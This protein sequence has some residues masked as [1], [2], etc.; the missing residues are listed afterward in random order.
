MMDEQNPVVTPEG[1]VTV[2]ITP[3]APVT[4][5]PPK[6]P[7][8]YTAEQVKIAED[9][10]AS[11]AR[12][13]ERLKGDRLRQEHDDLKRKVE[14]GERPIPPNPSSFVIPETGE[15]DQARATQAKAR[16]TIV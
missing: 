12:R 16:Q 7:V 1:E 15:I 5:E 3:E 4:P 6:D 10:A 13:E 2:E 8:V 11:G 9:R 14:A